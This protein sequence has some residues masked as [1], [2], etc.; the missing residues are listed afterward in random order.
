MRKVLICAA[1]L[2]AAAAVAL[3]VLYR[4]VEA[5]RA[6][7]QAEIASARA[8]NTRLRERAAHLEKAASEEAAAQEAAKAKQAGG[9]GPSRSAASGTPGLWPG[10]KSVS[11]LGNAGRASARA[12]LQTQLWAARSGD[13][14]LEAS[15]ITFSEAARARL[16][17]LAATLPASLQAEYNTPE[18]LMAYMLAGSPHP[19]GG[20]QL[21]GETDVDAN[22][23][24]IQMQWQHAD[25]DI[26]HDSSVGLVQGADG[27]KLLLPDSLVNRASAYLSRSAGRAPPGH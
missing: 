7:V 15:S 1:A 18:L 19:V 2:L 24:T 21:V 4:R 23:V 9:D 26:I 12:A 20:V 25:D 16:Q 10:M 22:D 3:L 11:T 8:E 27:W 14:A 5:A 17:A 13:V 6:G